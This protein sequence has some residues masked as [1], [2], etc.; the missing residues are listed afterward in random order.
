[1]SA[2]SLQFSLLVQGKGSSPSSTP[3]HS[4]PGPSFFFYEG[5]TP[6]SLRTPHARPT[7]DLMPH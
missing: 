6:T 2:F 5:S 3:T 4:V 7:T 1:M